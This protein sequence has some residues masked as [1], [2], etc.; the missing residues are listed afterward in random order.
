MKE[1]TRNEI[2]RLHYGGASQRRIAKLLG[3]ARKSVA[4]MLAG[5]EQHRAEPVEVERPR[6][7]SVLDPFADPIAQLLERY[8][9]ITAVRLHEE[10]CRLGFQGR[11]TI[12]RDRLRLLRPHTPKLPVRRFETGPGVQAQMDFSPYDISFTAEGRRRVHAF[13]YILAYSRRQYVRFVETQDLATTIREHVRAFE[14]FEGL[15]AT[16]LYDNMKVVVTGYD[17]D[18]PIYNTRFLSFA[19]R[20]GRY[21]AFLGI[22]GHSV[23]LAQDGLIL[24]ALHV[25]LEDVS[26]CH[27]EECLSRIQE[28]HRTIVQR[29]TVIIAPVERCRRAPELPDVVPARRVGFDKKLGFRHACLFSPFSRTVESRRPRLKY[30]YER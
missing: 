21:Q 1:S 30:I 20:T 23:N 14:Y 19:I 18:Q 28:E 12:V 7:P 15:A 24:G 26:G 2:I 3:V 4:R 11:Y 6:R 27:G 29:V 16:C 25:S 17:G 8:P 10:L 22:E 9:N 13:S 5:H